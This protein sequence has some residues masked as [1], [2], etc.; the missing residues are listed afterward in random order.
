LGR[1]ARIT[2]PTGCSLTT[3]CGEDSTTRGQMAVFILRAFFTP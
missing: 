3:Y 2:I 1:V